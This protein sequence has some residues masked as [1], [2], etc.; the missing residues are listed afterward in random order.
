MA[1]YYIDFVYHFAAQQPEKPLVFKAL[2]QEI[3]KGQENYT[4][5]SM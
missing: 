4:T 2:E 5:H 1:R 3:K